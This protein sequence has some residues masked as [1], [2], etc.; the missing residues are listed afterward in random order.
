MAYNA[1]SQTF[2]GT[3]SASDVINLINDI[4][5]KYFDNRVVY[6]RGNPP[7]HWPSSWNNKLAATKTLP[8]MSV[9]GNMGTGTPISYATFRAA[10]DQ[11]FKIW[12]MLRTINFVHT[13]SNGWTNGGTAQSQHNDGC[14]RAFLTENAY[15]ISNRDAGY[16]L[17]G[18]RLESS[19]IK[20]LAQK[21]R[22]DIAN[23]STITYAFADPCHS[24]CHNSC[25]SSCHGSGGFR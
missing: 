20:N 24:N 22:N 25:H 18:K 16:E 21:L 10:L 4:I 1:N 13:V 15:S 5:P 7:R 8:R 3:T 23:A 12:S 19:Y 9:P 2:S 14:A 11:M 17:S 6:W